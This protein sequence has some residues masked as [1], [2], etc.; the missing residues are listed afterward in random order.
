LR[1]VAQLAGRGTW[2][3]PKPYDFV[4]VEWLYA[5]TFANQGPEFCEIR[6]PGSQEFEC[7]SNM[8]ELS[9]IYHRLHGYP[10]LSI[11]DPLHACQ[12]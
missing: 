3:A 8:F 5:L 4:L 6:P 7:V 9:R 11:P 1:N 12:L 10:A 2:K